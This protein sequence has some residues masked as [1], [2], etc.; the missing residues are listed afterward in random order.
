MNET[1]PLGTHVRRLT[2]LTIATMTVVL[3]PSLT[4]F[5]SAPTQNT[6]PALKIFIS[7]DMEGLAG[8]A[9]SAA[10]N[11]PGRACEHFR[12]IMAAATN[13]GI[14]GAFRAGGTGVWG[15][16]MMPAHAQL[17]DRDARLMARYILGLGQ[18]EP[19]E[20]TKPG[21]ETPSRL[22]SSVRTRTPL[23]ETNATLMRAPRA[24][25]CACARRRRSPQA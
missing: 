14:A 16:V 9:T 19:S 4:G 18:R 13:A 21:S 6:P 15:K 7:V 24:A 1:S 8:V 10:V 17:S 25:R 23:M 12:K 11:A 5:A 2:L 20:G 22:S 3:A